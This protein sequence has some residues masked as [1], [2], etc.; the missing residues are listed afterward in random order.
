MTKRSRQYGEP[1]LVTVLNVGEE[2]SGRG[3]P[4]S[5]RALRLWARPE[6]TVTCLKPR[7]SGLWSRPHGVSV[8]GASAFW[9]APPLRRR[10][11]AESPGAPGSCLPGPLGWGLLHPSAPEG[12]RGG[13]NGGGGA[14]AAAPGGGRAGRSREAGP[15]GS[16]A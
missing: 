7:L 12:P 9:P 13:G 1:N 16:E 3:I 5:V 14:A 15:L 6:I 11:G 2:T 8:S 10:R 4:I